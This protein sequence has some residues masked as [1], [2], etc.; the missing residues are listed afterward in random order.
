LRFRDL[1]L[2]CVFPVNFPKRADIT[3]AV[4]ALGASGEPMVDGFEFSKFAW[5]KT[6]PQRLGVN[7]GRMVARWL[8]ASK[9]KDFL[10]LNRLN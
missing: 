5:R 10:R 7:Y 6:P 4:A 8:A 3:M 2:V 9:S 1:Y